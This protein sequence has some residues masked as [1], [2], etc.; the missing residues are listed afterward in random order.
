MPVKLQTTYSKSSFDL[1]ITSIFLNCLNE[2]ISSAAGLHLDK[3]GAS[4]LR[5]KLELEDNRRRP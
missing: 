3:T 5:L 1:Q 4:L 2:I